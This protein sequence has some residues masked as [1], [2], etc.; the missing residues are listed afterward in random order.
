LKWATHTVCTVCAILIL[1]FFVPIAW[2]NVVTAVAASIFPDYIEM[3]AKIKHRSKIVH[4]FAIPLGLSPLS[5]YVPGMF[6]FAFG[7]FYHLVL[8]A[9][10]V[11]GVW[12]FWTRIRG[13]CH[14]KSTLENTLLMVVHTIFLFLVYAR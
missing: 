8:D 14:A 5:L 7:Y 3:V 12:F 9:M 1:S 4:N 6:G 10:T 13:W 11:Y 2:V